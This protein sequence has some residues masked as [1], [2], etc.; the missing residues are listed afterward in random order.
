MNTPPTPVSTLAELQQAIAA[1]E[2]LNAALFEQHNLDA[3]LDQ[4]DSAPFDTAWM[5]SFNTISRQWQSAD[6]ASDAIDALRQESFLASSRHTQQHEI[7]SYV[8]DDFELIGKMLLLGATE[9][10][11]QHL[12]SQYQQNCIP[13]RIATDAD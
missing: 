8:S 1:G 13:Y 7:A 2:M 4:R 9:P 5:A 3:L 12:L 10:F 11:V 6:L